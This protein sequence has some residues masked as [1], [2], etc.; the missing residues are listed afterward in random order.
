MCLER[1]KRVSGTFSAPSYEDDHEIFKSRIGFTVG[2]FFFS[3][4]F[5]FNIFLKLETYV[6]E[7]NGFWFHLKL[8]RVQCKIDVISSSFFDTLLWWHCP[9][10]N[11][12]RRYLQVDFGG[13]SYRLYRHFFSV[14]SFCGWVL[15]RSTKDYERLLNFNP[16]PSR[17]KNFLVPQ[18]FRFLFHMIKYIT[19]TNSSKFQ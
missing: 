9:Y 2:V 15:K 11:E 19:D 13:I 7:E 6:F 5:Y 18:S 14:S 8:M 4:F 12:Q 17:L 3:F 16:L 10:G 1:E